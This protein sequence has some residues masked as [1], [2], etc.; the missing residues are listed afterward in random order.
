MVA[1]TRSWSSPCDGHKQ[2]PAVPVRPS[3]LRSEL[4][5]VSPVTGRREDRFPA[6]SSTHHSDLALA[7]GGHND[8]ARMEPLA[9]Q[10][11]DRNLGWS[12]H[13]NST[14]IPQA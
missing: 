5:P 2:P 12:I 7:D 13:A 8:P 3:W 9:P 10:L 14:L 4:H 1:Y 11:P 6:N